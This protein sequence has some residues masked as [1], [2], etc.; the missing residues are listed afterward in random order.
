MGN[1]SGAVAN[2][3][4]FDNYLM[5]K[6]E[7][8][9]S[10]NRT[11]GGPNWVSSHLSDEWF[12]TLAR[13][14]TFR[15]DPAVPA[16]WYRVQ[17]FDFSGSGF[18]RGHMVPN[19][20]RDKETSIPINQA[21][22]LMSN[23]IAQAPGNN[24]GPWAALEGDLR[25]LAGTTN[26][27]YIVTGPAGV[28]GS[29]SNG[30]TTMTLAAGNVTV[31]DKTWKVA[32][33]LTKGINDVSRV[34]CSTRTI[35]VIMPNDDN[36]RPNPW[37][38]YLTTVDAVEDL[39]GY[40]FFSNV[41]PQYQAC[42]EAG[43][44]GVNPPLDETPPTVNCASADGNWHASNVSLLCTATDGGSGLANP[45]DASFSLFTSVGIAEDANASTGSRLVCDVA[46]N[47][48][49]A[50]PIAGNKIDQQDPDIT[51]TMPT[52]G[53]VYHQNEV[54][55]AAYSCTD[56]G[57]GLGRCTGTVAD[58]A[59]LDTAGFGPKTFVVNA[60]DAVG[61]TSTRTVTYT[62]DDTVGPTVVCESAD[63]NWHADNVAFACTASDGGSGLANSADASFSLMTSVV[64]DIEDANATSDLRSVCDAAGNCTQAGP[65]TGNKIDL[66]DPEITL[67][68]PVNGAVYQQNQ[69]VNADFS[70]TDG[71]SGL[72]NCTGT[73]ANLAAI[74][75]ATPGSKSFVVTA[76]DAVGNT[77]S[78]TVNYTVG[79]T[80]APSVVCAPVD[81]AW[82]A[83]NVSIACTASDGGSGLADAADA[84][85][86]LVTSVADDTADANAAS[87]VRNVCD[88]AGNCTQ[89][90]PLAGNQIDLK[91][92]DITLTT[93]VNGAV[94]QLNKV[95]SAAYGCA[96]TGSGLATCAGNVA[97]LAPID[98][99]SLG[100]KTFTVTA[101]DAVGNAS[102]TAVSYTVV[103]STISI[104]NIPASA[105]I[106]GSFVPA[107]TY[108]G[109]GVTSVTSST[110]GRC[111]VSGGTVTFVHK[112]TCTLVAH[113][114]GTANFDAA[115]G[116]PQT[117]V[118]DKQTT[119][120]S[121]TNI[122][123]AA[124]YGGSFTPTFAYTGD[125]NTRARSET[126]ATCRVHDG[127]VRFVGAGT[128]T[129]V[130]RASATSLYNRAIGNP[131]SFVIGPATPTIEIRNVPVKPKVGK[132]FVPNFGYDGD[133]LTSVTSS[134]ATCAVVGNAVQFLS[135][136]TC[137]LTAYATATTNYTAATGLPESFLIK[138]S[139]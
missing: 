12:G 123:G 2:V 30:G 98:T 84:A 71:G 58:L 118:I 17:S 132:S 21:T 4:Q 13:V 49:T 22:F 115:T 3:S 136:G 54:V 85:F 62:I 40:D 67:T 48:T 41:P 73:I 101:T 43:T 59:A 72:G 83:G 5:E 79:D 139:W 81:G 82:H 130:A 46:G 128:C 108:Q 44:N 55:T 37:T 47:C 110:P 90:G 138:V 27:L 100:P 36:I 124:V 99:A 103:A 19:A 106:G 116:T 20:D 9:L 96:D 111:T 14:D 33:V 25:T 89:A 69:V 122:P 52:D 105:F 120:V 104:S 50:G 77:A 87:G 39:T 74:D 15:A 51:I 91:D 53:A 76:T 66:K 95:V 127:E 109:D 65:I 125:G 1:P 38:N 97:N 92:P 23:M 45:A 26:E 119:T 57:S 137:T 56:G 32:L 107:F 7:F 6:P 112:G 135:A 93:P 60:T 61:N 29:G 68:T 10:Y 126:P 35:A 18:D 86:S 70:C 102:S 34:T 88:V 131:Q 8:T 63:G 94:Y 133:G 16:D 134:T 78:R 114:T 129:L 113:A 75:T 121:I 64:D 42:I 28:G 31:P 11:L 117:A 80:I 24:Q